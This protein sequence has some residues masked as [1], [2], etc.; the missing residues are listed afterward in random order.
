M[1]RIGSL[2][3]VLATAVLNAGCPPT[4]PIPIPTPPPSGPY[5]CANPPALAG[6]VS[7]ANAIE[8][9]YIVVLK[10][11]PP[12]L[13]T[14]PQ[15][16]A[17]AGGYAVSEVTAFTG[18][19]LGFAG[20]ADRQALGKILA[21]PAVAF[22][23]EDGVKSIPEPQPA[24][25]A[26]TWGRDRVDQRDLPL[27][28]QYDPGADGEGV[29]I[30]VI[31]TGVTEHP[32]FAGRLASECF[33]AHTFGGCTDRHGHGTHVAGS[34]AGTSFGVATKAT[35][36]SVRV[37]DERGSGT[38]SQVIAGIDW[39]TERKR[40]D[41]QQRWVA[42]MSLGGSPSPALDQATCNSIEAG[43]V[44]AVAA[45]NDGG[46]ANDG[47][48]S[49]VQQAITVGAMDRNDRAA[50]FSN[51]GQGLALWA[52]GVDVESARPDGGSATFSGTSMAS[53]HVAG[54]AALYL[55]RHPG[56]TPAQ[57]YAGVVAAATQGK[58]SGIGNSPNALLYVKED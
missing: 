54:G 40:A 1:K 32:D 43:V 16:E 57:V 13:R 39:V 45:G 30:A 38:D 44:H 35:L 22:V 56:A 50:S 28:G 14:V 2:A 23:Q 37:L 6:L 27:D 5:D 17:F 49:R 29:H 15:I 11:E 46:D 26:R 48:P 41:P 4:P 47:S 7:V 31:D 9:R 24:A 3:V 21:D 25:A 52:P 58:L 51:R 19:L 42:N 10:R 8:D 12:Q 33:T 20:R 53:P 55:Q 36:Y 18:A 34:A